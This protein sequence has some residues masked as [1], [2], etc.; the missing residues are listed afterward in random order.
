[1]TLLR[2]ARAAG[3]DVG[4]VG[5][6]LVIRGPKRLESLARSVLAE[7]HRVLEALAD[8][9]REVAW[10]IAA[11][12]PQVTQSGAMPLLLA[13]RGDHLPPRTCCSC[14]DPLGAC[15][16]YRCALCTAAVF[17]VLDEVR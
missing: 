14:G 6:E 9:A 8:E 7:K 1:M 2:D 10:R 5:E 11:M 4:V 3:L 13:R 16:R 12:R 17:A 15:D